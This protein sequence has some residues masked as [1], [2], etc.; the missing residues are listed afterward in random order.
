MRRAIL[1]LASLGAVVPLPSR[2]AVTASGDNGFV[3]ESGVDI[4]ADA[5]SV[6]ALIADPARWWSGVHTY[7]GSAANLRIDPRAG[8]CFCETLPAVGGKAAGSIEHGRVIYAVPGQALR[9]GGAL[10]PLQTEG[11][12]GTLDLAIKPADK[13]VHVT[14]T[15]VVGGYMRMA[16][17]KLAPLVDQVLS[18][19]L[20]RLKQAAEKSGQRKEG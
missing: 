12:V 16:P 7:S 5:A 15:Y 6:Y 9:I 17:D 18:E 2:A 4:A 8:G 10:G 11:V 19:Q 13:G 14:L 3:I 20:S 1:F